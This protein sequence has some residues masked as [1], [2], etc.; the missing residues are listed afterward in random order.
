M[1]M[2][3]RLQKNGESCVL[4]EGINKQKKLTRVYRFFGNVLSQFCAV[5]GI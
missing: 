3:R 2:K 5:V 4:P 1:A